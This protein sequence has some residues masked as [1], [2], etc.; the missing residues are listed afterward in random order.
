MRKKVKED[1]DDIDIQKSRAFDRPAG[2]WKKQMV[3]GFI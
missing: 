1:I 3:Y 2:F